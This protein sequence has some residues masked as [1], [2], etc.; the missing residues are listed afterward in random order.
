[1]F[2]VPA[3]KVGEGVVHCLCMLWK[4]SQL[5]PCTLIF[6]PSISHSLL[7]K[8]RSHADPRCCQGSQD[9]QENWTNHRNA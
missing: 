1:M 3:G 8:T 6:L 7:N 4:N 2:D 5:T 9:D